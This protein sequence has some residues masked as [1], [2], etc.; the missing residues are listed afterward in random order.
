[1]LSAKSLLKDRLSQV[2]PW[3]QDF[4]RGE[5]I[6]GEAQVR[7]EIRAVLEIQKKDVGGWIL[8]NPG[9]RYTVAAIPPKS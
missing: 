3:L 5:A 2:R 1:M 6:Y 8:F 4:S 9:S 7:D